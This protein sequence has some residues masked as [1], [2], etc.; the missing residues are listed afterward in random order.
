MRPE[1]TQ[2]T[3]TPIYDVELLGVNKVFAT[4]LA[5]RDLTLGVGQGI[6]FSLLGETQRIDDPN[7]ASRAGIWMSGV[8][9]RNGGAQRIGAAQRVSVAQGFSTGRLDSQAACLDG[10]RRGTLR[11]RTLRHAALWQPAGIARLAGWPSPEPC[12]DG[13]A[14]IGHSRIGHTRIGGHAWVCR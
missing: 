11:S 14:R 2:A 10:S 13:N 3:T 9:G 7:G 4:T 1:P 8:T 6:F 12:V 5:V